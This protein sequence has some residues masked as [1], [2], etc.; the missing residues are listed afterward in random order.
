MEIVFEAKKVLHVV[1]GLAKRPVPSS[2]HTSADEDLAIKTWDEKNA[3]ARIF[4]SKSIT[5]KILRKLTTCSTT[6]TMWQKIVFI[7]S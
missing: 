5:Q 6:A 4:I 7:T 1:H 2:T 3:N